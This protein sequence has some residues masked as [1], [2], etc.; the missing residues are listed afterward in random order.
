M[1]SIVP[2]YN[3]DIF[4]SYRQKDNKGDK[5]VSEFVEALRTELESTFKEEI[6]L[7]FDINPH[8]GLLETHDVDESLKEKLKSLI[9]IPIIS[10]TYCDPK[11]FAWEHEFKAFVEQASRDQFGLKVK[12][13][14]GNV[15]SRV[16]PVRIY[17]LSPEDIEACETVMGG[18]LRSIEFIYAEPG[19]NRPLRANED[20]PN[21]N[22]N[23]T[24]YRNQINK[25]ANSIQDI[26]QGLK[27]YIQHPGGFPERVIEPAQTPGKNNRKKI[28]AGSVLFLLLIV[29]GI[30]FVPGRLKEESTPEKSI[31][32]LPF[33]LLSNEPDKQY[34]ADGMM[35]A[36]LLHLSKIH[37]LRVL[38]ST[39]VEQYRR[40]DKTIEAIG[41]ELN[42]EYILEGNFQKY[43]DE[44]KLIV[45]LIRTRKESHIWSN[46][47]NRNWNDILAVQS[48]VAKAVASE[49]NAVITPEEKE[50]IEARPTVD[51]T[52]YDLY[53]RA[54]EYENRTNNEEDYRYALKMF[55]NA[56]EIDPEFT[57]AWVGMAACSRFL[58]W[59]CYD[60]SEEN[61][62]TAKSYLDKAKAL[63]PGS[64]EV[65]F[66]EAWYFYHCKRDYHR[67]IELLEKLRDDY[68]NDDYII[69]SISFVCR[70]IGEFSRSLELNEKALSMN[71]SVFF[72]W[73]DAA[74]TLRVLREYDKAEKYF[75]RTMA[76]SPDNTETY[77]N[78]S[79][80]YISTGQLQALREFLAENEEY[81]EARDLK[82]YQSQLAFLERNYDQALQLMNSLSDDPISFQNF[83]Y[84]KHLQL[85]LICRAMGDDE[86]AARHFTLE[87][88]HLTGK[89]TEAPNDYRLYCSLGIACAGLGLKEEAIR[90]GERAIDLLGFHKDALVGVNQE[91]AMV[92]TLVLTGDYDE[93]MKKL[94]SVISFHGYITAEDLKIDPFWDPV[95]NHK[96]FREIVSDPAYQVSL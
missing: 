69:A 96:K 13:P 89:I 67:A 75:K 72:Y 2:G 62:A 51:L 35:E 3:Y 86:G 93:A 48:E 16:L 83:Y 38:G 46:E 47:Y 94:E 78:L 9:F 77:M 43:G 33:K 1:S 19:V 34:L 21:D 5:W 52:A 6:S 64:K 28:I 84:T 92:R 81:F 91:M 20:N 25:V 73:E 74:F 85:G 87:K 57:L 65:R 26:L 95:R 15:A 66:E 30:L 63:S 36:I 55:T 58:Y 68:P 41:K 79:D 32:V 80:L 59:F 12:L 11:S 31:A 61:L 60:L 42:V 8:D 39:S 44:A 7:Y 29:L 10:R 17:D 70:R 27:H 50:I 18:I 53:I 76:I 49:L 22:L 56:V 45:Q 88:D 90:A 54:K 37:D 24:T 71:S 4:I 82:R 40:T 23:H 14:N